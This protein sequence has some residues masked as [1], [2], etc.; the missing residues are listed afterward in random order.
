MAARVDG[1][2]SVGLVVLLW[3][4]KRH[5]Q[6]ISVWACGQDLHVWS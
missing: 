3:L 6:I 5:L 1:N 2:M 4:G